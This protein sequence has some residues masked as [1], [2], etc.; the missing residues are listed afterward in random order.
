[1]IRHAL[2]A[3][4]KAGIKTEIIQIGGTNV[5]PCIACGKCLENKD[6]QCIQDNDMVNECIGK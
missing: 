6:M 4:E 3:I 1:M 2:D 5:H